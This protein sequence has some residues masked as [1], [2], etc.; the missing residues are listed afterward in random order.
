MSDKNF[1]EQVQSMAALAPARGP[2]HSWW[3]V[4][5][6]VK[7]LEACGDYPEAVEYMEKVFEDRT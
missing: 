2:S 4:A 7:Q 1:V 6:A 5:E 3:A